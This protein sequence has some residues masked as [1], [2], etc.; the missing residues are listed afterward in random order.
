M[1]KVTENNFEEFLQLDEIEEIH[2]FKINFL[3]L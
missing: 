3:D 2:L 1:K